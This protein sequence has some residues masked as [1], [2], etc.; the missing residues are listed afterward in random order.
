MNGIKTSDPHRHLGDPQAKK[1]PESR[2]LGVKKMRLYFGTYSEISMY[3]PPSF[4]IPTT[5]Q[6]EILQIGDYF[7]KHFPVANSLDRQQS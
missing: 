5:L 1:P 7:R 6:L 4:S 3:N 2:V